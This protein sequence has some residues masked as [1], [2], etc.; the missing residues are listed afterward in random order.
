MIA[1]NAWLVKFWT[2]LLPNP[3][4]LDLSN[5]AVEL[6]ASEG[7][8]R[9]HYKGYRA[10]ERLGKSIRGGGKPL[11][12]RSGSRVRGWRG[13]HEARLSFQS[14]TGTGVPERKAHPSYQWLKQGVDHIQPVPALRQS[15]GRDI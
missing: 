1:S 6:T 10:P 11:R 9:T 13:C 4:V 12:L 7:S 15:R 8:D 2:G 5:D 3:L 14:I